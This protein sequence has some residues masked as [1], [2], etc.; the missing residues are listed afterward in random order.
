MLQMTG[1]TRCDRIVVFQGP[2]RLVGQVLPV[3]I[4]DCTAHTLIG[5]AVTRHTV[6][7]LVSLVLKSGVA[8]NS[9]AN[10]S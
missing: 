8:N 2:R 9:S 10:V 1:R 7:E 6:P 3:A 5:E 4:L